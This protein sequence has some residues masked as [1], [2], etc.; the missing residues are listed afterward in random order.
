MI[1]ANMAGKWKLVS[2]KPV[3]LELAHSNDSNK[4]ELI[5]DDHYAERDSKYSSKVEVVDP[6]LSIYGAIRAMQDEEHK[7][8]EIVVEPGP[9]DPT[10]CSCK[11]SQTA[12]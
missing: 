5:I 4:D 6:K 11:F 2:R 10:D 7:V 9:I 3:L 1:L 12:S 8:V